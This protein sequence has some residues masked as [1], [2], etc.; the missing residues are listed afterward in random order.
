MYNLL[1]HRDTMNRLRNELLEIMSQS[2]YS[3]THL[4]WE[5]MRELPYLDACLLEASRLHPPFCLPFE[6]VVP[7]G[8]LTISETYLPAG[9]VVGMSPYVINRDKKTFGEDADQWRPERWLCLS[10]DEKKKLEQNIL[11]V[12]LDLSRS[13]RM[14]FLLLTLR[15]SLERVVVSVSGRISLFSKSK[16]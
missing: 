4:S 1:Q 16:S 9:T 13:H 5:E 11:T 12:S 7:E 8:G 2:G 14:I 3:Q 15:G 10:H 6:R